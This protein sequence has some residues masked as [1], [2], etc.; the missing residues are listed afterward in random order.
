MPLSMFIFRNDIR[1][2]DNLGLINCCKTGNDIACIFII[3][4]DKMNNI[5]K[6]DRS[7]QFMHE[8]LIELNK[9]LHN[10]LSIFYGKPCHVI[11]TLLTKY[12]IDSI[13]VN[14]D[15]T[16]SSNIIDEKINKAC[17]NYNCKLIKHHDKLLQPVGTISEKIFTTFYTKAKTFH[18]MHPIPMVRSCKLRNV[19][20]RM[21]TKLSYLKKFYIK[22]TTDMPG[23]RSKALT[24]LRNK[25]KWKSYGKFKDKLRYNTTKLSPHINFGTV[26]IREVHRVFIQNEALVKQ[27]YWR[28]FFINLAHTNKMFESGRMFQPKLVKWDN[29]HFKHWKNGTTGIPIVDACMRELK[30]TGY[31]H[32]SG[33]LI[34]AEFAKLMTFDWKLCENY[35]ARLLIDND[36]ILNYFNW[37]WVYGLGSFSSPWTIVSNPYLQGIKYDKNAKYIKKWLPELKDVPVKDI[38]N[39]EKTYNKYN[40][41]YRKPIVLYENQKKKYHRFY[42][43]LMN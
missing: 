21:S 30:E 36:L 20:S 12:R 27:L 42:R 18:V 35:Y 14:M 33:K 38:H 3:N 17:M 10:N 5:Y 37:N 40:G 6:S 43:Y 15:Y 34:A 11:M 16:N 2:R 26:S 41:I 1:L 7:I 4:P 19:S 32:N 23:G 8:S 13:H 22:K 24:I 39:W 28:E 31:C 29:T 9:I 25:K